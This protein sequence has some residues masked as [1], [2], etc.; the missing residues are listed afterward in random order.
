MSA[1]ETG[2]LEHGVIPQSFTVSGQINKVADFIHRQ[3][4][5][6]IKIGLISIG[7]AVA[8]VGCVGAVG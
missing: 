1:A 7:I 8:Q 3:G 5:A 2:V 4:A 6:C